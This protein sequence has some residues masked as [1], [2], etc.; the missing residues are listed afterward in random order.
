[1]IKCENPMGNEK[2]YFRFSDNKSILFVRNQ[3]SNIK[4][5]NEK[6]KVEFNNRSLFG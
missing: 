1:M 5:D 2:K 4:I 3:S 6:M